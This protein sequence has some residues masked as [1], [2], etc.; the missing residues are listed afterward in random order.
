MPGD[1]MNRQFAAGEYNLVNFSPQSQ[2][3]G[4]PDQKGVGG[5][6][7]VPMEYVGAPPGGLFIPPMAHAHVPHVE[8]ELV[9]QPPPTRQRNRSQAIPIV[10][11]KVHGVYIIYTEFHVFRTLQKLEG[12]IITLSQTQTTSTNSRST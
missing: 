11:P 12:R 5:S 2:G 4:M 3:M 1:F 6:P 7:G 10:P 9:S 8:E